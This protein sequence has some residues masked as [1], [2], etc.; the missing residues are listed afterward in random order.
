MVPNFLTE[1]RERGHREKSPNYFIEKLG[2]SSAGQVTHFPNPYGDTP[3]PQKQVLHYQQADG[4]ELAA[5]LYV[6]AGYKPS[7]GLLP[8]LMEAPN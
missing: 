5:N 2:S 1:I 8:T 6:P 3:V 4:V 7:D